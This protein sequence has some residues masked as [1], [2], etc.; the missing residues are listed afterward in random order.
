MPN[1]DFSAA[2]Q[3]LLELLLD[4]SF[5]VGDF[6]LASGAKSRFY[7][8]CRTTTTHAEGQVLVG[9]LG[10]RA[11][12]DAGLRPSAVG[13]LTMGADPVSYAIAH[14]SWGSGDPVHSFAVRKQ[15]KEHGTSRRIEGCFR[16]DDEVVI[17]E[18]VI[19]SGGSA[20]RA[21]DAVEAEG[22]RI[23]AVLALVDRESGGRAAIEA[24]GYRVL[25]L[26]SA[27][28]LLGAAGPDSG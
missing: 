4:R 19:T 27:G 7:I 17:I 2:R 24:A 16:P 13:G 28:E 23:L 3:R 25:S 21:C 22:G 5:R 14:A 10:L 26:F 20:L 11:L 18:D 6:T 15:A 12:R 9:E 1:S 8:D